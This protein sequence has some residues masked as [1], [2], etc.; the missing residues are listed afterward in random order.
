MPKYRTRSW[1]AFDPA[2][3][4]AKAVAPAVGAVRLP[5]AVTVRILG[6]DPG[7]QRTGFGVIECA[8]HWVGNLAEKLDHWGTQFERRLS[9]ALE[10]AARREAGFYVGGFAARRALGNELVIDINPLERWHV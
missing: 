7:S 10:E 4:A 6:I 9:K 5:A 8:A 3:H 1:R 2:A